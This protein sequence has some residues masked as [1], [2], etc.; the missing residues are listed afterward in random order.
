[1][2]PVTSKRSSKGWIV[3]LAL[4]AGAALRIWFIRAYPE[5]QGD[6][7]LYGDIAKNWML[8]GIYGLSQSGAI[9]PTLI[10][11]PGYPLFLMA[12]F[13]LLGVEHYNAVMYA[14]TAIDLVTCLLIAGFARHIWTNRAG[15]WALW[16]AALCP[17][18]ANYVAAP[19]TEVPELFCVALAFYALAR[20]LEKPGWLWAGAMIIAWSY[21]T[22]LR[23][24]GALL[25]IVL[26]PA[27]IVYG[28]RRWGT[29]IM[30]RW[31]VSCAWLAVLPF[32][33][34]ALRNARTFHVFE[35]LAPRYAVDPGEPTNP[36]F[37]RWTKTVCVD[38]TCTSDV[39]WN[40]D[41]DTIDLGKLPA[42]AFDSQR[43]YQQT[44]ALLDAYNQTTTITPQIDAAFGALASERIHAHPWRYYVELPA[45]RLADMAF[46][47]R[48]DLLWIE[49]RWW[50]FQHHE[51]E[52]VFAIAYAALNLACFA[53]AVIGFFRRPPL[54]GAILT[55]VLFRCAL[56]FTLEASEP[57]Y[58]L[59]FF[60]PLIAL[61]AIA[62]SGRRPVAEETQPTEEAG[63]EEP[64]RDAVPEPPRRAGWEL[65]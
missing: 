59:E 45:A 8:H 35:P 24:D 33:L 37:N 43:Q 9:H 41:S 53:A 50:E 46:R 7:F 3:L 29:D 57:R 5:V 11:L 56:L 28:S 13:H 63:S 26:C 34:W 23:P 2:F 32:A 22:L 15:W 55:F 51:S 65:S 44:K 12:C 52:T 30:I 49:M 10:R 62:C 54:R 58:T 21:A 36:G 48:T 38:L 16:L 47:P 25:G 18:T 17:F 20:F 64:E 4:T 6:T 40:A 42:R 61:A 39:Y 27:L 1:M 31:A 60:P 19:L 14:Q